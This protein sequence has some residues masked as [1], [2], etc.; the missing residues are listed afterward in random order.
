MNSIQPKNRGDV[1]LYVALLVMT[2]MLAGAVIMGGLLAR[3]IKLGRSVV[4]TER[5][6][7]GAYSGLEH[8]LYE[9]VASDD[10]ETGEITG[11]VSYTDSDGSQGDT[12]NYTSSG[13]KT[14]DQLCA[15]SSGKLGSHQRRVTLRGPG[16]PEAP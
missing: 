4:T 3:Q 15:F 16:C 13:I 8:A 12:V 10:V 2:I 9:L 1:A 6:F 11:T 5:A 7:Y 14:V